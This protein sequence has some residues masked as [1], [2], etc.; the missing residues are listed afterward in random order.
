MPERAAY[1]EMLQALMPP[2]GAWHGPVM[3]ELLDVAAGELARVDARLTALLA[4]SDPR[5][6]LELLDNWERELGLPGP[7]AA[8]AETLQL[9]REQAHQALTGRGGQSPAW[10]IGLAA[11]LGYTVTIEEFAPFRAG[12]SRAGEPVY[13]EDWTWAW[14]VRVPEEETIRPFLAGQSTAGEPLAA[15]GNDLLECTIRRLRPAHTR[16]LFGYGEA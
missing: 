13:G 2:G 14:R 9:R 15:W 10:F 11:R 1:R 8:P 12:A 6:A 5:R 7:C 4:E 16:V 3:T